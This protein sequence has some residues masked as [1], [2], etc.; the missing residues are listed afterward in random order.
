MKSCNECLLRW[1]LCCRVYEVFSRTREEVEENCQLLDV[2][3]SVFS[4][5][6]AGDF[7]RQQIDEITQVNP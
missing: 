7:T 4:R 2:F 3:Q 5:L 1:G 6:L